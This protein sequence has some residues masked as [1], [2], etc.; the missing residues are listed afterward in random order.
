MPRLKTVFCACLLTA[1]FTVIGRAADPV[2]FSSYSFAATSTGIVAHL[3]FASDFERLYSVYQ[4]PNLVSNA[5]NAVSTNLPG[6]GNDITVTD[7]APL[8]EPARFYRAASILT[9]VESPNLLLNSDFESPVLETG[10]TRVDTTGDWSQTDD[11]IIIQ[12]AAWAAESGDQGVWMKGWTPNI[13]RSFYQDT[14]IV[15][16][17][18][19]TLKAAFKFNANFEDNGSTLT[20]NLIWM[21][22]SKVELSRLTLDVNAAL[23]SSEDW[24]FLNLIGLAPA[25]TATARAGFHIT[26]DE[27]IET[28]PNSSAMIDS[29]SLTAGE[30]GGSVLATQWSTFGAAT[31]AAAAQYA[32]HY[33]IADT[34]IEITAINETIIDTI[35]AFEI[36]A[37]LPGAKLKGMA[38]TA[39]GRQLFLSANGTASDSIL[40]Y[41]AG[42]GALRNFITGL[43]LGSEKLG[44]SH[45]K[46]ELFVGTGDGEIR[47]Y[48]APLDAQTGTYSSSINFSGAD[49]GQPVRAIAADIQDEMLYVASPG[50]LY[51][52]NPGNAV[53]T[54]I[55]TLAG[56][57]AISFGRTYGK[58]DQ[59][60]LIILQD[61]GTKRVLH[62]VATA[63]LQAGGPVRPAPYFSTQTDLPDVAAT[64]CGRLLAAGAMPCMLSD[65]NDTRMNFMEW[66]ADEFLQN[67]LMAKS[68]CWQ[69]SGNLIGMVNNTAKNAGSNRGTVG[70][71]DAAYWVVNQLIM[72]DEI[73][74]DPEAQSLVREIIK[75]Y[76]TLEVNA[77]GQWYHW[78]NVDT[79]D[80]HSWEYNDGLAP[81]TSCFS[82]MKA[83]HMAIRA[84][85]YYPNDFEIVTAAQT[86]LGR[87][88]NQRDYIREYGY[89]KSSADNQGPTPTTKGIF[90][91]Y[92]ETHLFSELMAATEP[93]AENAYLDYWR[94]RDTHTIDTTLPD[95]P[96]VRNNASGFWR[97]Y[98][99]ATIQH[100]RD[101]ADWTQEFNN[102]YALFA[103]WT[104]DNAPEHL[105][106]FS[107]GSN[108]DG[109]NA[110]KY[111]NHPWTINSLGTV[112]GFGLQGN[113][114]PVV[115]AYFAYR[116]GRRQPMKGSAN[117]GGANMLTRIS[118]EDPNWIMSNISPTDH[119]YAGYALGEILKPGSIDRAI[120]VHT[121]REPEFDGTELHFSRIVKRN[122]MGTTDGIN[123]VSLG[124]HHSPYTPP[125]GLPYINYT[126]VGA[127]GE[128]L[129]PISGQTY[130][131]ADDFDGTL[132]IVRAVSTNAGP[133]RVQWYNGASFISEQTGGLSG[134][135]V[136][137]PAGA[138]E[139]RADLSGDSF[140][141]I[142]VVLDGKEELFTN[143]DFEE[144]TISPNWSKYSSD[145]GNI[146]AAT[147]ADSRLGGLRALKMTAAVNTPDAKFVQVYHQYD[148]SADP[149][150]THYVLEFDTLTENLQGSAVNCS[151]KIYNSNNI[152][153]RTEYFDTYQHADSTTM[154]SAGFRK[155]ESDTT[156]FRMQIRL[157]RKDASVVTTEENVLID[158]LRLLKM[159]P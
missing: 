89:Q 54:E 90:K 16:G 155:R 102:F 110:D 123:W 75:R 86:I 17:V 156:H 141:Q 132:Y 37:L 39:S 55:A 120:A 137:K 42:T 150:N 60:G 87:L 157:T 88:R 61:T 8:S 4:S 107:A 53:L 106:A 146:N 13:D 24:N 52:L 27:N 151:L 131:V 18:E 145:S 62:L 96:I 135:R 69:D 79:G 50:T 114:V 97:M 115:G 2:P 81:Q 98:D 104:D 134:L 158:N 72:S 138:T 140:E 51:R 76:A 23:N 128:L 66:V 108:P 56:I 41:N 147:V 58:S 77:D 85:N 126:A 122:V 21:D 99:Q 71:P 94:Y 148:I 20:M 40:A 29:V 32:G 34:H 70:S 47:R 118:Y 84:M 25:G 93:M 1:G 64:A 154:L 10:G 11:A 124:F 67:V 119:Q 30:L 152:I 57:E 33:A 12:R 19:Y 43:T 83:C 92:I 65:I 38:F 44:L 7:V 9:P 130:D 153:I 74:Q 113:T 14:A 73:N 109:Y 5:W 139:L 125:A 15:A 80:L 136:I 28:G 3:E 105:T 36:E 95:E 48:T 103:G 117:Y 6:T 129:E 35:A 112:M 142:S 100:C 63:D 91:P 127:E 31:L 22:D 49:A 121:Y 26:T 68:L 116:D 78:Y 149:T 45:F 59:G 101:S 46:G 159:K 143:Y 133:L 144:G 82:T 111:I